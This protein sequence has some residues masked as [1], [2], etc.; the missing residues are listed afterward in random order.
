MPTDAPA[1]AQSA[2]RA[3]A[4][5]DRVAIT[6]VVTAIARGADLHQWD[7]VRAAF[8]ARVRLDYGEPDDLAPDAIIAR[9]RAELA[10][11]GL[12]LCPEAGEA[13]KR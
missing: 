10:A 1:P 12:W 6:D 11:V 3:P 2:P 7:A 5:R 4:E 9:C 8:A 13:A